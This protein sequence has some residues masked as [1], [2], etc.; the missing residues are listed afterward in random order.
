[1][2]PT[3]VRK[4]LK[5]R[6]LN[7]LKGH[8]LI[9]FI[10]C[11]VVAA[12]GVEFDG[13]LGFI[14]IGKDAVSVGQGLSSGAAV[15]IVPDQDYGLVDLVVATLKGDLSQAEQM[16]QIEKD[17]EIANATEF[18]GRTNGILASLANNI[19]SGQFATG[20]MRALSNLTKSDTAAGIIFAIIAVLAYIFFIF[21]F[22]GVVPVI[23]ARYFLETRIYKKVPL[24]RAVFLLQLKKWFH[25]AWVLFVRRFFQFLWWL[26]IVGGFIKTYSYAMVPYIIAENPS[27][28]AKEA[29]L[30]SRQMM[31]GYKWKTFVMDLTLI[32]WF[33]L[34]LLTLGLSD[35]FFYNMYSTGIYTELYVWLRDHAKETGNEL[36]AKL[37]DRWLFEK[38]PY[39]DLSK[40]YGDIEA[41]LRKP[42]TK[43][44]EKRGIRGFFA[45]NFGLVLR[46]DAKEREYE[47][48]LARLNALAVRKDEL[49][50]VSYPWR[51]NPYRPAVQMPKEKRFKFGFTIYYMRNYSLSSLVLIFVFF[52]F[53]GWAW[54]VILH[55]VQAGEWVNRGVLHGPWLPIYGSGG[56]L[57]LLLL[58]R[59]RQNP[60]LHFIGTVVLCGF[61][62]YWTGYACEKFLGRRYWSYDGYFLNLDGRICAEGLVAFGIGGIL[63]VYFLAPLVDDLIRRLPLKITIPICLVLTCLFIGDTIYSGKHP[64]TNTGEKDP[65]VKVSNVKDEVDD[66]SG[67]TAEDL[68]SDPS[69]MSQGDR[70]SGTLS[71]NSDK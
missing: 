54:E 25:V 32:G 5:K 52:S 55:F 10:L 46:Y 63:M 33:L 65:T 28:S 68:L 16:S 37:N 69:V 58:K 22:L 64:N 35:L 66:G 11:F 40:S 2:N 47:Q 42:V 14:S 20:I 61:V 48:D 62:E 19:G 71:E 34:G 59:L 53:F 17:N 51:L 7:N 36:A 1:M 38:A 30:L 9:L 29:I 24:T 18:L 57:M 31:D 13:T 27:M 23:M 26:T 60:I 50:G 3:F 4:D 12:L 6:S 43:L 70:L 15:D 49:E 44:E 21:I 41:E 45:R 8:Y 39:S 56:V 67:P